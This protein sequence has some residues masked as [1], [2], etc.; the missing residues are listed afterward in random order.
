MG[1]PGVWQPAHPRLTK[2]ALPCATRS[3][4]RRLAHQPGGEVRFAHHHDRPNHRGMRRAAELV[5]IKA[6]RADFGRLKPH[7]DVAP[8]KDVL[9]DA[10]VGHGERVDDVLRSHHQPHRLADRNVQGVDLAQAVG[11]LDL[12]HPLLGDDMDLHRPGRWKQKREFDSSP[13]TRRTRGSR[14]SVATVQLISTSCC[15]TGGRARAAQASPG[16][17]DRRKSR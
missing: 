10:K 4:S 2:S 5:A 8:R 17:S 16:D 13:P 9:L 14:A 12:P 11:M 3:A 1:P 7:L 15:N 6:E